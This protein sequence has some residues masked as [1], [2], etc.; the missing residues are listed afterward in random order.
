M[1]NKIWKAI[2]A[3]IKIKFIKWC[4]KDTQCT[5]GDV[6]NSVRINTLV[7]ELAEKGI[8]NKSDYDSRM[9]KSVCDLI[10]QEV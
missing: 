10:G 3:S 4:I 8:I 2:I 1:I 6:F 7:A 9:I 5:Y